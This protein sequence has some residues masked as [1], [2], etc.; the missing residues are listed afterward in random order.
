MADPDIVQDDDEN[1]ARAPDVVRGFAAPAGARRRRR[2]TLPLIC[3]A[4]GQQARQ[5]AVA[6][7]LVASFVTLPEQAWTEEQ[8]ASRLTNLAYKPVY[9]VD[10]GVTM[11][12]PVDVPLSSEW[13]PDLPHI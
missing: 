6:F 9:Y 7:L 1:V 10:Y 4:R 5:H 13:P 11:V 3:F 8:K 2:R 12:V